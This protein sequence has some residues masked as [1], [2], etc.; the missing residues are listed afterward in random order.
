MGVEK[1]LIAKELIDCEKWF[2]FD[3]DVPSLGSEEVKDFL[4]TYIQGLHLT[5]SMCEL[6]KDSNEF[7]RANYKGYN[8]SKTGYG[9][10]Y[11]LLWLDTFGKEIVANLHNIP[12]ESIKA[13]T[14]ATKYLEVTYQIE[15]DP[16]VLML[17]LEKELRSLNKKLATP[18]DLSLFR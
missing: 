6:T 7:L 5:F 2:K 15:I 17:Y 18:V 12:T 11:D 3:F 14:G 9:M 16:G 8:E 10:D 13:V 4:N 1:I